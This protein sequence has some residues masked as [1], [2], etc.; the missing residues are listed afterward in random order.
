MRAA[1]LDD[2]FE[3]PLLVL[4]R[5]RQMIQRRQQA[6]MH[7]HPGGDVHRGGEHIVRRL[8]AVHMVVRMHRL[9]RAL[10]AAQ[11]LDGAVRD[12]LVGVHVG[13]RA[14]AR[15]PDHQRKFAVV[16][17]VDHLLRR[18]DDGF[19]ELRIEIAQRVIGLGRALLDDA[20]RADQGKRHALAADLEVAEAAL[21]LRAPILAGGDFDGAERVGFDAGSGGRLIR[22][23][24][25]ALSG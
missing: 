2:A 23:C 19:G 24:H 10:L 5:A 22:L 6:L 14:G 16:L 8:P 20:E 15:L 25:G 13:L 4:Q 9:L 17:A 3:G 7:A 18:H 11:H 1:D 21:G 12:H